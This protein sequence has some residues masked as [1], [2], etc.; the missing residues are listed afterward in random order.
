MT[1][2]AAEA[3]IH[4]RQSSVDFEILESYLKADLSPATAQESRDHAPAQS[5]PQ[6]PPPS[7]V[8]LAAAAWRT[9]TS[10]QTQYLVDAPQFP[11]DPPPFSVS[12]KPHAAHGHH[13]QHHWR[14]L[15]ALAE[16]IVETGVH[17]TDALKRV[18]DS[19]VDLNW[20]QL[21]ASA[22]ALRS[23]GKAALHATAGRRNSDLPQRRTSVGEVS[24]S[25][26]TQPTDESSYIPP[27]PARPP[28]AGSA[29]K[30]F[31]AMTRAADNDSSTSLSTGGEGRISSITSPG[32]GEPESAAGLKA[33]GSGRK[34]RAQMSLAVNLQSLRRSKPQGSGSG[35]V[36]G[37]IDDVSISDASPPSPSTRSE[38]TE[39]KSSSF[40]TTPGGGMSPVVAARSSP[41]LAVTKRNDASRGQDVS[42][43]SVVVA[44]PPSSSSSPLAA[45]TGATAN[46]D[47][48][49]A[50]LASSKLSFSVSSGKPP[51]GISSNSHPSSSAGGSKA[52]IGERLKHQLSAKPPAATPSDYKSTPSEQ[53]ERAGAPAGRDQQNVTDGQQGNIVVLPRQY[54]PLK[55]FFSQDR[56]LTE[57]DKFR[58]SYV[59]VMAKLEVAYSWFSLPFIFFTTG[60]VLASST[61]PA[62]AFPAGLNYFVLALDIFMFL[63][64]IAVNLFMPY[65]DKGLVVTDVQRVVRHNAAQP[66][67]YIFDVCVC[68]PMLAVLYAVGAQDV[69]WG[70]INLI[71]RY[72]R[73]N[74]LFNRAVDSL[75]V[76]LHPNVVRIANM[77]CHLVLSTTCL[78]TVLMQ[79]YAHDADAK[80]IHDA[81]HVGIEHE[82]HDPALL[83]ASYW[84]Q[85]FISIAERFVHVPTKASEVIVELVILL[86]SVL[87]YAVVVTHM[88]EMV[89]HSLVVGDVLSKKLEDAIGAMHDLELPEELQMEI[90]AYY[91]RMWDV[92]KSFDFNETND[93][94]EDFPPELRHQIE[95]EMNGRIIRSIP[96]FEK[97]ADDP[98][99][100]ALL[101]GQL[102]YIV[103]TPGC[104]IVEK[105]EEGDCMFFIASGDAAEMDDAEEQQLRVLSAGSYFGETTMLF[106]GQRPHTIMAITLC[107][108]YVVADSQFER[109]VDEYPE[110]LQE[111][112][113]AAVEQMTAAMK[114]E[115]T[116][117]GSFHN[118]AASDGS[119]VISILSPDKRG[120]S[121]S[122]TTFGGQQAASTEAA[123]EELL[124]LESTNMRIAQLMAR[125]LKFRV[126]PAEQTQPGAL[127]SEDSGVQSL[128]DGG[129]RQPSSNRFAGLVKSLVIDPKKAKSEGAASPFLSLTNS[130]AQSVSF[131]VDDNDQPPPHLGVGSPTRRAVPVGLSGDLQAPSSPGALSSPLRPQDEVHETLPHV[132]G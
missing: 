61:Y 34:A 83:A 32:G 95:G 6:P 48:N 8:D 74:K 80:F 69:R 52:S 88:E 93:V 107:V 103:V 112:L 7:I 26:Q 33:L 45:R 44:V 79:F 102:Q 109:V 89:V 66:S 98:D 2:S 23:S 21:M 29:A 28:T 18:I 17:T 75:P 90:L 62:D 58:R 129:R 4:P 68:F 73:F 125:R 53:H 84:R 131:A 108:C 54:V 41:T 24:P 122:T 70:R 67:L 127:T 82:A 72:A 38:E 40:N 117:H 50:S 16:V 31:I 20:S 55:A 92:C 1:S 56:F 65:E 5:R 101:A 87:M 35:N 13:H 63:F 57:E 11:S 126:R 60:L 85:V 37:S 19:L 121:G 114:A 27:P 110:A 71:L 123:P 12:V 99:F 36:F 76:V 118:A 14:L 64:T 111:I 51:L 97:L 94:M 43:A 96:L 106:G 86:W 47:N 104:P 15:E 124:Q 3:Y 46:N 25:T 120:G 130:I 119:A 49:H 42:V 30:R 113:E 77:I 105:G 81:L 115:E 132:P 78:T 22:A 91:R 9:T 59:T 116:N 39:V 128:V 100:V 10:P